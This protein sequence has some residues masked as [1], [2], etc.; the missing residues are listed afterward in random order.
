[1]VYSK[2]TPKSISKDT[3][4]RLETYQ[5]LLFYSHQI[6][7][8]LKLRDYLRILFIE[9]DKYFSF[10][11]AYMFLNKTEP[12][13]YFY[14]KERLYDKNLFENDIKDSIVS[15]I[16]QTKDEI[17]DKP[18]SLK[19]Q[20]NLITQKPYEEDVQYLYGFPI[21]ELGVF[22][23]HLSQAIQDPAQHYDD[24]KFIA[25]LLYAKITDELQVKMLKNDLLVYEKMLESNLFAVRMYTK[26][27]STYNQ[28]AQTLFGIDAHHHLELFMRDVR[29]DGV[30]NLQQTIDYLLTHP[31]EIKDVIYHYQNKTIVETITSIK[32][33]DQMILISAFDDQSAAVEK[34]EKL[35]EK[36]TL[37]PHTGL[38]NLHALNEDLDE[39]LKDKASLML[40]ELGGD[41]KHIY[42]GV[43]ALNYFKEFGQLTKKFFQ[44]GTTYRKDFDQLLVII[45]INDIR[46]VTKMVKD[47][48]KM[49]HQT[50]SLTLPF[51]RFQPKMTILR[52]PVVTNEKKKS[53]LLH[54]LDI[55]LEK[56]KRL[57][58]ETYDFFV[59]RDYEEEVFEQQV[60]HYLNEAIEHKQLSIVFNQ[61]TDIKKNKIWQYE[62]ELSLPNLSIS[63]HYLLTL[64]KKRHR[65][66]DLEHHHI[67]LVCQFLTQLE[68]ETERLIK[69]T[70]PISLETFTEPS[71][72]T[73]ILERLKT[74]QVPHEFIRLKLDLEIKGRYSAQILDLID[75]GLSIDTTS[76]K[77]ALLYP[78]T[79]LHMLIEKETLKS[80]SY[81]T[82]IKEL[83]DQFNMAY[84]I[85]GVKSKEQKDTL[86][87]VGI[88]YLEGPLY[89]QLKSD[90][91]IAK[92]KENI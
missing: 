45:P 39:H 30:R 70:I 67:D 86:E 35:I 55:G 51:E 52:Y 6:D 40:I 27:R 61:I 43:D 89:K 25:T 81:M 11:E 21:G 69:I 23:V 90:V 72:N 8:K 59:Y 19:H 56:V 82:K 47:F 50:Q 15:L 88:T 64:A 9:I 41:L 83:C 65:L 71:F 60:I 85:R 92:I 91:L 68:K 37:D 3:I 29:H 63:N 17:F 57:K 54:Y 12:N 28:K 73:Y 84:I 87:R 75:H 80:L 16:N 74:Y 13:F 18:I 36:A 38:L 7:H 34:K 20:L 53:K 24:F 42:G 31:N 1:M 2:E 10:K 44:E 26:V 77:T 62:S 22:V 4:K 58:Q 48:L 76:L 32:V 5:N 78:V 79:A 66:I 49:I 46:A 14:K 33:N